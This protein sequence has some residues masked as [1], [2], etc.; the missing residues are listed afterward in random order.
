MRKSTFII[1]MIIALALIGGGAYWLLFYTESNPTNDIDTKSTTSSNGFSPFN[2]GPSGIVATSSNNTSTS[3]IINT[4]DTID[5]SLIKLPKLRK[6][7]VAPVS[8][9]SA[10]TTKI[11][12]QGATSTAI[13]ITIVRYID[14][15]TGHIFQ[16]NDL[17]LEI[18]KIS[19][20]T[21]PKIYQGYWNKNL[22]NIVTQY[23]K[24][25]TDMVTNFYAEIR[26]TATSTAS[27]TTPYEVKGKYISPNINQIAV[28][29][30]GDRIFTWNIEGGNGIGYISTFDERNKIKIIDTPLTQVNIDWPEVSTVTLTTKGSGITS[31]YMYSSNTRGGQ[32]KKVIGGI[33]G[34]SAIMS[35]DAKNVLYSIGGNTLTTE[36]FNIENSNSEKIV[37]NTLADKC[38]WSTL[39]K[40]EVYCA[41]PNTIP[42]GTYP[43]DWYKGKVSFVDKIW[44]LD[45]TTGEVHLLANLLDISDTL[46]DATYLTLDPKENYLYFINKNDLTLWS[47]DLNQP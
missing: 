18:E 15:G 5:Y 43:D 38:V 46:I 1:V 14:R 9:M 41:V 3:T 28:S 33:R 29:P 8:G 13:D 30:I 37:F 4:N 23:L 19:N 25:N 40:N 22:N 12:I 36:I 47:L 21:L 39:R 35:R 2:R 26:K 16:T 7:S 11:K 27:S 24:D 10:S 6:L 32:M 34:L 17:N 31:G 45:I 42:D 20:T 44:H